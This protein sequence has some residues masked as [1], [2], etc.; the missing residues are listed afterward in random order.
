MQVYDMKNKLFRCR[1]CKIDL[2]GNKDN[3]HAK[4]TIMIP[5]MDHLRYNPAKAIMVTYWNAYFER[6]AIIL[7]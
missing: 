4:I 6:I 2:Y 3:I 7:G 5:G 1:K